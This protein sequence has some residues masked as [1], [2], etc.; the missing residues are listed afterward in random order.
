[1]GNVGV[2]KRGEFAPYALI[3]IWTA[4]WMSLVINRISA[5]C[6]LDVEFIF[7]GGKPYQFKEINE[8]PSG[9]NIY[10]NEKKTH[11]DEKGEEKASVHSP[12]VLHDHVCLIQL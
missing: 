10:F 11:L 1:M 3:W 6:L 7:G 8:R 12:D 9:F 5:F 2:H 4:F